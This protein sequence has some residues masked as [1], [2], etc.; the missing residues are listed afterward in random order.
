MTTVTAEGL[1]TVDELQS[2]YIRLSLTYWPWTRGE[3]RS[4]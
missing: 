4:G 2:R 1:V 3:V